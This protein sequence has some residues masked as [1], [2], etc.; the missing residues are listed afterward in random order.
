MN[1]NSIEGL[2]KEDI[3]TLYSEIIFTNENKLTFCNA[4]YNSNYGR[5]CWKH[6]HTCSSCGDCPNEYR[7]WNLDGC[8][9]SYTY[10]HSYSNCPYST[11]VCSKG[12]CP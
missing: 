1:F 10:G 3:E 5:A 4:G 11:Q 9:L 7:Y 6:C 2:T 12:G 8:R